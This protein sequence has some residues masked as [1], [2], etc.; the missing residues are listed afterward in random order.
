MRTVN[1]DELYKKTANALIR[2]I[3]ATHGLNSFAKRRAKFECWLKVEFI[4]ALKNNGYGALPEVDRIDVTIKNPFVAIELKT[5]NTN[6]NYVNVDKVGKAITPRNITDNIKGVIDD[7]KKLRK[8]KKYQHK[9]I[10][11][12]AFPAEHNNPKWQIQLS[13]IEPHIKRGI[14]RE[15]TFQN[16]VPGVI[17]Y[18][19]IEK[20]RNNKNS[21]FSLWTK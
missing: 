16:Q 19:E 9:F 1:V 14:A 17:Y 21:R 13:K 10:I 18:G 12:I 2:K 4:N 20:K 8:K 3:R 6:Y 15:F 11:F 5:T 7:I